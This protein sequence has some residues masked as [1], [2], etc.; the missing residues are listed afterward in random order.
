MRRTVVKKTI[1]LQPDVW[2]YVSDHAGQNLSG[3]INEALRSYRRSRLRRNMIAGYRAMASDRRIAEDLK[4]WDTTLDDGLDEE[5]H[6]A[7]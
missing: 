6:P 7:R 4:L 3:F 1:S 5:D 2:Q